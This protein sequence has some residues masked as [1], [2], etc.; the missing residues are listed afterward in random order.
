MDE[1]YSLTTLNFFNQCEAVISENQCVRY[2]LI[3]YLSK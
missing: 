1:G 2:L 3:I